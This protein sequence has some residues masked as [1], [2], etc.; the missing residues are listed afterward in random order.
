MVE[1]KG[2]VVGDSIKTIKALYGEHTYNDVLNLLR[3][4]TRAVFDRGSV[5]PM[6]WYSLNAFIEFLEADLK[7]TSHGDERELIRRS[8]DL[9]GKQLTGIYKVFVKLGSPSFVLSR[10]AAVNQTYFRGVAIEISFPNPRN[11]I[12]RLTGFAK[13]HRL[14]GF[15]LIGFYRKALDVSGAKNIEVEFSTSIEEGKGYCELVLS[16]TEK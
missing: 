6:D 11:A 7:V 3:P 9:I 1:V 15:C 2:S 4:E 14:M 5:M 10:L 12:V 13:E 16:W 8:E